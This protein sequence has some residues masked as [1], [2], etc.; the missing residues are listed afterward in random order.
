M[1][2]VLQWQPYCNMLNVSN[3]HVVPSELTQ[4]Y[5]S[6]RVQFKEYNMEKAGAMQSLLS[7]LVFP[8]GRTKG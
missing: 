7:Q 3:Q 2:E 1:I 4:C 5:M 8:K 6:N